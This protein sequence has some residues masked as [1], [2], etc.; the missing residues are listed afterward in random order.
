MQ[1]TDTGVTVGRMFDKIISPV[2]HANLLLIPSE[3]ED[4]S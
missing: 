1:P 4:K 2:E 3:T